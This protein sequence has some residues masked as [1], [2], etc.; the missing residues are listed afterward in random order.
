VTRLA[1]YKKKR[2][3]KATPEPRGRIKR[4]ENELIFVV[5]KH[6]AS[7]L[8]FDLRLELE[9]VLKS[10][11]VPKGPST[12]ANEK[13]LAVMVEDHPYDYKDFS[14]VIPEGNYGA[15]VVTIWDNGTYEVPGAASTKDA[16]KMLKA[17]LKKGHIVFHLHGKKLKGEFN[18]VRLSSP[19]QERNWLLF[20]KAHKTTTQKAD[21]RPDKV[22]PMLATLTE[23]PFNKKEWIFELKLDGYRAIA[24]IDKKKVR[25]ISRNQLSLD[26]DFAHIAEEL[27]ALQAHAPILDGELVALDEEGRSR[28][29]LLQN[30]RKTKQGS[31]YYYVFDLLFCDGVDYRNRPLRERKARLETVLAD[32][33][34]SHIRFCD[35]IDEKGISL[36]REAKKRE[37]EGVIAK[38]AQSPYQMKRSQDWLKIKCRV[39]QE[40]FIGGFTEARSGPGAFGSLMLGVLKGKTFIYMGQVGTGFSQAAA[41]A[42]K[43]KLKPLIV[44]S[45]PFKTHAKLDMPITYVKPIL[46]CQVSFTEITEEGY[47][48]HPVFEGLAEDADQSR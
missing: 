28:F 31:V 45:S 6:Q 38:N 29:Q 32:L 10:W 37:L 14:G 15:G 47:L 25:L 2:N 19:G 46:K 1:L 41:K 34:D 3:P 24:D 36:F 11:A 20:A 35:H 16:E 43:A 48:R 17:G 22:S 30:F 21:K 13:R 5:Q 39:H 8:H 23:D 42:L 18:L 4:H 9:G 27:K 7:H 33:H 12:Q 40:M 44:P 26:K